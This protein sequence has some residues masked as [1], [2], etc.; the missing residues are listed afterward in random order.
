VFVRRNGRWSQQAYVKA[1]NAEADDG[2]GSSL[3]VSGDTLAVGAPREDSG[4]TGVNGEQT[5]NTAP[6]SGAVYIFARTNDSWTQQAY[7]KASNSESADA[8]GTAVALSPST[9][10][11]GAPGEK[12][13]ARGVNG[14]QTDNSAPGTGALYLFTRSATGWVQQAYV[15]GSDASDLDGFGGGVALAGETVAAGASLK[16]GSSGA[17]YVF[18]R[19]TGRWS[20]QAVL[21]ASNADQLDALGV[22]LALAE[23]RL[24]VGAPRE[25][26]RA[27]G[28][29][30]DGSDNSARYS[31]AAY[32]FVR[33][34]SVW[35]Q[36]AYVKASNTAA[37]DGF[38]HSVTLSGGTLAAGAPHEASAARG[39]NGDQTDNSMPV[40]G[41]VYVYAVP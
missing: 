16:N 6:Q 1:S 41:A 34:G 30:G 35:T 19:S 17:A 32:V 13:G 7:V 37:D 39:L 26:S 27:T 33:R 22:S 3:A 38:G 9:L 4:A 40:S 31:G 5:S 20:E 36:E 2:F 23:E 12:S 10:A 14:D 28:I 24:V 25:W 29:N 8:F 11:V 21:T 15:K 18:A